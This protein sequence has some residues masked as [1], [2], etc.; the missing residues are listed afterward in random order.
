MRDRIFG[1]ASA[2]ALAAASALFPLRLV[3]IFETNG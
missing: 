1:F 3:P 2:A